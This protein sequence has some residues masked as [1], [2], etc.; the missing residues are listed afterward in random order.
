MFLPK[1]AF[2]FCIWFI[3]VG[4][5]LQEVW[6]MACKEVDRVVFTICKECAFGDGEE[7]K[8][9]EARN[10]QS[11]IVHRAV[12]NVQ[13]WK[14]QPLYSVTEER[15]LSDTVHEL[16]KGMGGVSE[17]WCGPNEGSGAT[18]P[19]ARHK[20]TRLEV[21]VRVGEK[22]FVELS[23]ESL[24]VLTFFSIASVVAE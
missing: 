6:T 8:R 10:F 9:V 7:R 2:R 13:L 14:I 3:V 11:P 1:G 17:I 23:F 5:Y 16:S 15:V 24:L 19:L 22:R 21:F 20:S 12:V 18:V 4:V